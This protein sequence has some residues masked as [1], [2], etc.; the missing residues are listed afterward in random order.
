V[1]LAAMTRQRSVLPIGQPARAAVLSYGTVLY[2][3]ER[4][5]SRSQATLTIDLLVLHHPFVTAPYAVDFT[6]VAVNLAEWFHL[7]YDHE[8]HGVVLRKPMTPD[9]LVHMVS[10]ELFG[11][12]EGLDIK[13]L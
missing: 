12:P 11:E 5:R 8:Y 6:S 10:R 4:R 9:V 3:I 7:T 1:W 13:W 2:L